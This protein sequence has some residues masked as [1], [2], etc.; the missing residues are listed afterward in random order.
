M[1]NSI[2]NMLELKGFIDFILDNGYTITTK[3][4][5]KNIL[6]GYSGRIF[7][8]EVE[9]LKHDLEDITI[10]KNDDIDVTYRYIKGKYNSLKKLISIQDGSIFS[11]ESNELF[12]Y[13][14][15]KKSKL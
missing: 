11:K 10:Y 14:E 15:E 3:D 7:T 5:R 13:I 2:I 9:S 4:L 1:E 6:V 8:D 12:S